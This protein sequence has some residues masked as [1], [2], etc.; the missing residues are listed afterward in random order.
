M[1]TKQ[2]TICPE[3]GGDNF[4]KPHGMPNAMPQCYECGS[5]PRFT[6]TA[7]GLPSGD[8]S[9]PSTPAKQTANGGAGGRN[10]YNPHMIIKADGTV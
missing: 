9:G 6:Q 10:N 8:K 1:V 4:F 2:N 3:C 7:A 5:N